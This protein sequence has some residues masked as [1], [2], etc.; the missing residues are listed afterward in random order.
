VLVD[1][2]RTDYQGGTI[3]G[4]INLPAQSLYHTITSLYA[5]FKAAGV[6]TVIWYCGRCSSI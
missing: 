4:S 5:I 3:H 6:G 1:L 2:R